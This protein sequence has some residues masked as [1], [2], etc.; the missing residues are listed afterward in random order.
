MTRQTQIVIGA[1]IIGVIGLGIITWLNVRGPAPIE[2][3]QVFNRQDRG[4]VD[5]LVYAL[6]DYDAPPPGGQHNSV[7]QDCAIYDAPIGTEHALHS[8]EHGAVWVTYDPDAVSG[9]DVE[10]LEDLVRSESYA[11]LSPYPGLRSPV[12]LTAWQVQLDV[13]SATDRRVERFIERY[14]I[15]EFTPERGATCANG[16]NASMD[17]GS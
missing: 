16:N 17:D 12:V 14:Q 4:H 6:S 10:A 9:S 7:W 15:S 3:V 5:D 8:L 2:G 1:V 11:M 13:D